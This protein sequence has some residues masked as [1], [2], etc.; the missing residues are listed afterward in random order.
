MVGIKLFVVELY[1]KIVRYIF[2]CSQE[3]HREYTIKYF[4]VKNKKM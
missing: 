3:S 4:D 2:T 1:D